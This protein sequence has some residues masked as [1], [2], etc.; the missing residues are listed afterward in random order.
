MKD[1]LFGFRIRYSSFFAGKGVFMLYF[2]TYDIHYK[3]MLGTSCSTGCTD[4]WYL[5]WSI[6]YNELG[7][8][9]GVL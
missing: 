7:L 1:K 4:K 2:V 8:M 5:L 6:C 3:S 9:P